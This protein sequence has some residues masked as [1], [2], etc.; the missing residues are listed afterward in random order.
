MT[1]LDREFPL[2]EQMDILSCDESFEPSSSDLDLDSSSLYQE[3][4]KNNHLEIYCKSDSSSTSN[5]RPR[6]AIVSSP[7]PVEYITYTP[8]TQKPAPSTC[9]PPKKIKVKNIESETPKKKQYQKHDTR[10]VLEFIDIAEEINDFYT[11]GLVKV[12]GIACYDDDK[13]FQWVLALKGDYTLKKR[14][15]FEKFDKSRRVNRV[16]PNNKFGEIKFLKLEKSRWDYPNYVLVLMDYLQNIYGSNVKFLTHRDWN[17]L[18][19]DYFY[20]TPESK[21]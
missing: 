3:L 17:L 4:H 13:F 11:T 21:T 8:T 9:S 6:Y 7:P 2:F 14:S 1:E 20:N 15:F 5:K 16:D 19:L 18:P 10:P 12:E